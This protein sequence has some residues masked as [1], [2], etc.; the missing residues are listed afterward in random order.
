MRVLVCGGRDYDAKPFLEWWLDNY[1]PARPSVIIHGDAT[2]AD[3]LAKEWAKSR[4]IKTL[5]FPVTKE[6]W[7]TLKKSA[8]PLR[9]T[10]MLREGR[11]DVVVAFPGGP[12][13]ADM[14]RQARKAGV[15]VIEPEKN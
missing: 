10:R 8:G 3:T 2:G 4:G 12:G 15:E 6:E 13:T 5:P 1:L 9:N 14:V 11:P 7:K